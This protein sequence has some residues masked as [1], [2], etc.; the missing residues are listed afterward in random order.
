[1]GKLLN[2]VTKG[3]QAAP[4]RELVYGVEGVGKTKFASDAPNPIFLGEDGTKQLDVARFP[5]VKNWND[6]ISAIVELTNEQHAYETV[7]IDTLDHLELVLWK[8]ICDD[9]REV[10]IEAVGGGYGKG[11][12]RAVELWRDFLTK[13]TE[14]QT[15]RGMHVILLAH[16]QAEKY[17]PPMGEEYDRF[18]LK[19]NKQAAAIVKGWVESVLFA[20]Y[21]DTVT[22]KK[23]RSFGARRADLEYERVLYTVRIPAADAKNRYGLP[24]PI[25]LSFEKFWSLIHRDELERVAE[26]RGQCQE[27]ADEIRTPGKRD[28][29]LRWLSGVKNYNGLLRGVDRIRE[30]LQDQDEQAGDGEKNPN[31]AVPPSAENDSSP[32]PASSSS[33][34]GTP[35]GGEAAGKRAPSAPTPAPASPAGYSSEELD[36]DERE[37]SPVKIPTWDYFAARFGDGQR[38]HYEELV[39]ALT[40]P[41]TLWLRAEVLGNLLEGHHGAAKAAEL[42]ASAGGVVDHRTEKGKKVVQRRASLAARDAAR[43]VELAPELKPASVRS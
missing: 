2:Q 39:K 1:M 35:T 17:S 34:P 3:R 14:L 38:A 29:V 31:S 11:Y 13:L 28:E 6:V 40:A 36:A 21:R 24:S 8:Q 20:A 37:G 42:W 30:I 22:V 33:P 5:V 19:V 27:L 9:A 26:L 10:S 32:S 43:L 7:A 12:K 23:G 25:G 15:K 4:L 41:D 18:S 16:A